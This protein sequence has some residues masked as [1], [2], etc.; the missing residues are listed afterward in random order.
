[1]RG[2]WSCGSASRTWRRSSRPRGRCCAPVR[3]TCSLR[4]RSAPTRGRPVTAPLFEVNWLIGAAPGQGKTS[5]VR[6]LACAA[7]LDPLADLWV[8]E[9]AGKGDLEPLAKCCHR[10]VSGLDDEAIGYAAESLAMLRRELGRRSEQMKKLPREVKPD[11][12]VTR[13]LAATRKL[14]LRPLVGVIDECQNVFMHPE[15]GEQAADDAAY[16]IRLGRAYGIILILATQRPDKDS[17]PP[18]IRGIVTARFCLKVPDQLGN[19]M[20]LGTGAYKSGYDAS[21]F[22]AKTDAG[23]G[24]LKGE[25]DP[26]VSAGAL[27]LP[28][29]TL[30]HSSRSASG[31]AALRQ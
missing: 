6:V 16:V 14:R 2:A 20:I 23:L 5:A 24:W 15:L 1:M 25:G 4:C 29:R 11:G 22:R 30:P 13:T 9:H 27:P 17:L 26:Q 8:H 3:L 19:D 18:A 31:R 10:Y 12:K 28:G 7:A 21:A